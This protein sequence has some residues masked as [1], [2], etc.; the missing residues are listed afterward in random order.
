MQGKVNDAWLEP[1]HH[2]FTYLCNVGT[3]EDTDRDIL[4][5]FSSYKLDSSFILCK[6][7]TPN[8]ALGKIDSEN[9]L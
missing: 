7:I 1:K 5:I 4:N 2:T 9:F 8:R 6:Y 3:W